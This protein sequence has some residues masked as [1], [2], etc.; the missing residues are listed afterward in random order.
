MTLEGTKETNKHENV[1]SD[2]HMA[3]RTK[4]KKKKASKKFYLSVCQKEALQMRF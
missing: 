4:K 1:Y 3:N 2:Q